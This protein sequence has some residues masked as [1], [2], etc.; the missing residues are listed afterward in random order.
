MYERS[1]AGR[2]PVRT[3]HGGVVQQAHAQL[4]D[5]GQ[6]AHD[7][8]VEPA[9]RRETHGAGDLIGVVIERR[10]Q[11][12]VGI[13]VVEAVLPPRLAP[14]GVRERQPEHVEVAAVD[15]PTGRP[16]DVRFAVHRGKR[17]EVT[18]RADEPT[19]DL[20]AVGLT[21]VLEDLDPA[22]ARGGG[23]AIAF[24][25]L[26]DGVHDEGG[27]GLGGDPGQ[28]LLEADVVLPR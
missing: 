20:R 11:E 12:R 7:G 6:A 21:A 16:G 26:T 8:V 18:E 10:E 13:A 24:A 2:I 4:G 23:D 5:E 25:R 9:Q 14:V 22:L 28:E 3:A 27:A 15:E 17:G 1:A 19:A